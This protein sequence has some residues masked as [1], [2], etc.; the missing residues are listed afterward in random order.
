MLG[1]GGPA[2]KSSI[3]TFTNTSKMETNF[4]DVELS[5]FY[6]AVDKITIHLSTER[7]IDSVL[8]FARN[9][10][11]LNNKKSREGVPKVAILIVN[12]PQTYSYGTNDPK[13]MAN[14]LRNLGIHLF[15]VAVGNS[16]DRKEI[17][18][19]GQDGNNVFV[20]K[21]F[22]KLKSEDFINKTAMSMFF[23][24]KYIFL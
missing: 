10:I 21:T 13:T 9:N 12:G 6:D 15:V 3:V 16:I 20:V 22:K 7:R 24:G 18:D 1:I 8:T 14:E 4:K 19:I 17:F 23:T 5:T 2:M 11:F